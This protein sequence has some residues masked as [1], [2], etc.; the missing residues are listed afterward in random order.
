MGYDKKEIDRLITKARKQEPIAIYRGYR[1]W[2]DPTYGDERELI[3]TKHDKMIAQ[4]QW[5]VSDY[6]SGIDQ[7]RY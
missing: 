6:F 4:D 2:E 5:E 3:L 7:G 1:I